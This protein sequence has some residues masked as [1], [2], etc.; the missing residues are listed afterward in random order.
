MAK[1]KATNVA[2]LANVAKDRATR[3]NQIAKD[4]AGIQKQRAK[5]DKDEQKLIAEANSLISGS[6]VKTRKPR[7]AAAS[8]SAKSAKSARATSKTGETLPQ[9]LLRVA[10]SSKEEPVNKDELA[11]RVAD[12]GYESA[13]GDPKIVI[14]QALGAYDG[15]KSPSRGLWQRSAAGDKQFAELTDAPAVEK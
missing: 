2:A 12:A 11:K 14:G 3:L 7:K 15:F 9:I 5:L 8:K 4:Q 1:S 6:P 10:P 13:S